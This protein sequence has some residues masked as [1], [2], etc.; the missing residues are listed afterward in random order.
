MLEN[1]GQTR[2]QGGQAPC[3]RV[4]Y[5]RTDRVTKFKSNTESMPVIPQSVI[6]QLPQNA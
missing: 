3:S 1:H 6:M 4:V 2:C 5:A